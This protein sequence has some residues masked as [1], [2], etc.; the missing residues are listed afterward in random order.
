ML[1]WI[2]LLAFLTLLI[3]AA[4]AWLAS[5]GVP[6]AVQGAG[7]LVG[8]LFFAW[9]C[10][11]RTGEARLLQGYSLVIAL[12]G[13]AVFCYDLWRSSAV[14]LGERRESDPEA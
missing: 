4:F 1:F 8:G 2:L 10:G 7:A 6:P 11:S 13:L 12:S 5:R 3:A 14:K 9:L